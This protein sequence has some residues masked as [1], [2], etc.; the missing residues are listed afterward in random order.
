VIADVAASDPT[1][2]DW[3][4]PEPPPDNR[5][6]LSID[7]R[8]GMGPPVIDNLHLP[9]TLK[10]PWKTYHLASGG[11]GARWGFF[12]YRGEEYGVT[13]WSGPKA[14]AKDRAAV[15]R[16]LRSIRAPS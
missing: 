6:G 14:P 4:W 11:V 2:F 3:T 10:Q 12:K 5:V 1:L 8:A 7:A 15:L 16:A 9:L 13:Y